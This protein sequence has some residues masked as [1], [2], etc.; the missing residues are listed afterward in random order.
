M[1][2]GN[3]GRRVKTLRMFVTGVTSLT[4]SLRLCCGIYQEDAAHVQGE[5]TL[6][7]KLPTG[8]KVSPF[9]RAQSVSPEPLH[10]PKSLGVSFEDCEHNGHTVG[11]LVQ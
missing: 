6:P 4:V 10:V 9:L 7:R 8:G 1:G 3:L 11:V 5:S 2:L